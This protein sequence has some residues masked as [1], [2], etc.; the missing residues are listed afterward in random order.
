MKPGAGYRAPVGE[1]GGRPCSFDAE[2]ASVTPVGLLGRGVGLEDVV[3][4]G[5]VRDDVAAGWGTGWKWR[6]MCCCW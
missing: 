3:V 1:N 6:V 2:K 5:D 4:D